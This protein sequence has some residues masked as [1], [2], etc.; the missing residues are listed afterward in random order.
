[1]NQP[2]KTFLALKRKSC[3]IFNP[4]SP[5]ACWYLLKDKHTHTEVAPLSFLCWTFQGSRMCIHSFVDL[6]CLCLE[7]S[8]SLIWLIAIHLSALSFHFTPSRKPCLSVLSNPGEMFDLV[9]MT[10][11]HCY[12]DYTLLLSHWFSS[13]GE[14]IFLRWFQQY[15]PHTHL[16]QCDLDA[17]HHHKW[18]LLLF[19]LSLGRACGCFDWW[20][21][22][23]RIV[24]VLG[25]ALK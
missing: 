4:A 20:N 7:L 3:D 25:V 12:H 21:T 16:L 9:S 24:P 23:E 17:P 14:S 10:T 6:L 13:F 5:L 15:L 2:P 18:S 19:L 8:F 11:T 22:L 1:M